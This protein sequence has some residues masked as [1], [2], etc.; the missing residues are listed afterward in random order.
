MQVYNAVP[1]LFNSYSLNEY[2]LDHPSQHPPPPRKR[3]SYL[4]E[5]EKKLQKVDHSLVYTN[6]ISYFKKV[7]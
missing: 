5:P 1:T 4:K 7:I 6:K 3:V 2:S